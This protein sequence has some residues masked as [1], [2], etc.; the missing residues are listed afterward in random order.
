MTKAK[1]F[2]LDACFAM[3]LGTLV[4]MFMCGVL[5]AVVNH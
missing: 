4:A 3:W 5:N 2:A 1:D